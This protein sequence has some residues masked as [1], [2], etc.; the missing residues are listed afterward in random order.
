MQKKSPARVPRS[1][2][3]IA[4]VTAFVAV[5]YYL[6]AEVGTAL[7]RSPTFVSSFWPANA[8]LLGVLL[9]TER[10]YWWLYLLAAFPGHLL[11]HAPA[12]VPFPV[13]AVQFVSNTG[14]A[15][16]SAVAFQ[17]FAGDVRRF[18][19]LAT[20]GLFIVIAGILVP[21]V[22]ALLVAGVFVAI[23]WI[24][25]LWL[26]WRT[27]FQ[28]NVLAVLT[29]TPLVTLAWNKS[30]SALAAVSL[31]R[32][33]EAY[34][35]IIALVAVGF[36]ISTTPNM[37]PQQVPA[38]LYLPLPFLLWATVRFGLG[39]VCIAVLTLG[40]I[41]IWGAINTGGPFALG[42]P[43]ERAL[44]VNLFLIVT[45]VPLL[46]LASLLEEKKHADQSIRESENL[47]HAILR[48]ARDAIITV[49][50]GG[51]I[52]EFN[53]AAEKLFG[54]RRAEAIG[55]VLGGL[56]LPPY[57]HMRSGRSLEQSLRDDERDS[58]GNGAEMVAVHADGGKFP[59]ELRVGRIDREGAPLFTANIR[60][61]TE[62]KQAEWKTLQHRAELAHMSR[63]A[64]MGEVTASIAH[65]INQPLAA[66][67]SSGHAGLRWLSNEPPDAA[68]AKAALKRIVDDGHR[69]SSVIAT[70]RSMFKK[71][72]REKDLFDL[73]TA[74]TDIITLLHAELE[75]HQV[76]V[77][78]TLMEDGLPRVHANRVQL[79]QVFLNLVMN[80]LEAMDSVA[81]RARILRVSSKK[82]ASGNVI[83]SI[84]DSGPGIDPEDQDRIFDP[85]IT[86]KP[87]GMGVGLS[88]CRSIV[89]D[90][91]GSLSV[92]AASPC[93]SVFRVALPLSSG[94]DTER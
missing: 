93:G 36:L 54:Y 82:A 78:N 72:S 81:D 5:G 60:D 8:M 46:M 56:I 11:A 87:K 70:V 47:K 23:D 39:G 86:S 79:Q 14:Q 69:A 28:S 17:H 29:L 18:D 15:A 33:S 71:D 43:Q 65:E 90:H 80:A 40:V 58:L 20:M 49:D 45:A 51:R 22:I 41:L 48:S 73:N 4:F 2:T 64:M 76:S 94:G 59:V 75:R 68:E 21:G 92:E 10:R 7:Q 6:T 55:K 37:Q 66:I 88:I 77:E 9:M 67:V 25:A 26:A 61:L 19:R 63:I 3:E 57:P 85:F 84:E 32:F 13:M 16:L 30:G 1:L 53:P 27:R 35:L 91:G 83:V 42:T 31:P 12:G 44:S 89:E 74:I 24:D 34:M 52:V 38:L 62:R 50:H